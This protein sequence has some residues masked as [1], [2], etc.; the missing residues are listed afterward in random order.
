MQAVLTAC[1]NVK[2]D[3]LLYKALHTLSLQEWNAALSGRYRTD[4]HG[5]T[6]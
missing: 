6:H 5:K 1:S 4:L 3:M 2:Q